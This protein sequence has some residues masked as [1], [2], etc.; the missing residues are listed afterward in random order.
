V[1]T[2]IGGDQRIVRQRRQGLQIRI[3]SAKQRSQVVLLPEE[4]GKTSAHCDGIIAMYH[5]PGTN[6]STKL[7]VR[8]DQDHRYAT[9]GHS[10]CGRDTSD[11]AA[12][13]D[14]RLGWA[15]QPRRT[16]CPGVT[17]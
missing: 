2:A 6:P 12:R 1:S 16:G 17:D 15:S 7:L 13:D 8:L 5:R 14:N 4:G 11:S 10:E 9:F 3:D